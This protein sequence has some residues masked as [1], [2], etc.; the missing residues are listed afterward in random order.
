MVD[1]TSYWP[2]LPPKKVIVNKFDNLS[3][4]YSYDESLK[5]MRMDEYDANHNWIDA[6]YY[7]L[8][9]VRGIIEWGDEYPNTSL[10]KNIKPRRSTFY[11]K[12]FENLWGGTNQAIH[13]YI[14]QEVRSWS[15]IEWPTNSGWNYIRF[16]DDNAQIVIGG[17]TYNQ[18]LKIYREET[19]NGKTSTTVYYLAKGIGF[20]GIDYVQSNTVYVNRA[21]NIY[22]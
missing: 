14:T 20:V 4:A 1:V 8:D 9:P 5:T 7:R 13:S 10:F 17:K 21:T 18:C 3:L 16:E 19:W 15:V 6:W 11:S 12:G 2:L 22:V